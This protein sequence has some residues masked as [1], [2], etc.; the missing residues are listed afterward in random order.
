MQTWRALCVWCAPRFDLLVVHGLSARWVR[1]SR[2]FEPHH[3]FFAVRLRFS[4][5]AADRRRRG[6]GMTVN[7]VNLPDKTQVLRVALFWRA[8]V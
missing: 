2:V 4:V 8:Q 3:R 1:Q 7:V 6:L 5:A